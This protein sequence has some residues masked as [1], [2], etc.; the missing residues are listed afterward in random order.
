[1]LPKKAYSKVVQGLR[2]IK[3]S[4]D[5]DRAENPH[6]VP[7]EIDS[8]L[9]G[10]IETVIREEHVPCYGR[11]H[12]AN[13]TTETIAY[14]LSKGLVTGSPYGGLMFPLPDDV[15]LPSKEEFIAQVRQAIGG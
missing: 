11:D 8:Q 7:Y 4:W 3:E 13:L 5:E 10:L 6:L 15:E 12:R 2:K 9:R 1:M 14:L